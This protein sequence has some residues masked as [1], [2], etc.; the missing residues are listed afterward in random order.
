MAQIDIK[1]ALIR[2]TDL[3]G[4]H[5]ITVKLGEGNLTWTEKRTI[6]YIK[7]RGH[8]DGTRLGDEEPVE[9][10]LDARWDH[11]LS[12]G[13]E[14]VTPVEAIKC[15]GAAS[16]VWVTT[17]DLCEPYCVTLVLD[18]DSNCQGTTDERITFA[19]F[20]Y[21]DAAFDLRAGTI[22]FKGKCNIT[23]PTALRTS[24]E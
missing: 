4:S 17:G 21:E 7:D 6:Q 23:A 1:N 18:Y 16:G 12:D 19:F 2:I 5:S 20:R 15:I 13:A 8:L 14:G 22:S 24:S 3:N 11:Y 9:I 10:S